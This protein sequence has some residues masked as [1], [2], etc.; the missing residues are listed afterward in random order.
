MVTSSRFCRQSR[1]RCAE[2]GGATEASRV[3]RECDELAGGRAGL[4]RLH[5]EPAT[6]P[7]SETAAAVARHE[8][9]RVN[10]SR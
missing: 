8:G 7:L 6:L 3:G 9:R 4:V 1:E 2:S 10:S 5:L